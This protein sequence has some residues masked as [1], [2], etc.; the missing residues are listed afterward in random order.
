MASEGELI[1][2]TRI[3]TF[4]VFAFLVSSYPALA[5]E[6]NGTGFLNAPRVEAP[7]P[8]IKPINPITAR[9]GK[10][11]RGPGCAATAVANRPASSHGCGAATKQ[12]RA[13][14]TPAR[15]V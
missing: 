4:A 8:V 13:T 15:R 3:T 9:G 7:P 14:S 6:S 11:G 1:L 2:M 10:R 12:R 5:D